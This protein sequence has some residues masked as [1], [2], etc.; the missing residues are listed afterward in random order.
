MV[1][2]DIISGFLGSGKTTFIKRMVELWNP[3]NGILAIIENDFGSVNLDADYLA[4]S[5]VRITELN[6]GCVCCSLTGSLKDAIFEIIY[7]IN[8][9][10]IILEPSGVARLSDILKILRQ[11]PKELDVTIGCIITLA[12]PFRSMAQRSK[13]FGVYKNQIQN[14]NLILPGQLESLKPATQTEFIQKLK[15]DAD[16]VPV[17]NKPWMKSDMDQL[18]SLGSRNPNRQSVSSN[19]SL[20]NLRT[21]K[22]RS[23]I[24]S[25]NMEI[26]H[27]HHDSMFDSIS[28][29]IKGSSSDKVQSFLETILSE[30]EKYGTLIRAKG[31]LKEENGN[32]I[33]IDMNA[34][35][36]TM[37]PV[38]TTGKTRDLDILEEGMILIGAPLDAETIN[39]L[40]LNVMK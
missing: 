9:S 20:K 28:F 1:K 40:F 34:M 12:I 8:P 15:D 39:V 25:S 22:E 29:D 38:E 16:G 37:A 17:W 26:K 2:I 14:A 23:V 19:A 5:G 3:E 18:L 24:R 7:R 32:Y 27:V 10:H 13:F 11:L 6:S 36:I 31:F 4:L 30:P 35:G 21:K 33:K